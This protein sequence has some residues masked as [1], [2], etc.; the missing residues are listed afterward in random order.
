[1]LIVALTGMAVMAGWLLALGVQPIAI[2]IIISL[3]VISHGV[4][5]RFVAETGF[6]FFRPYIS[7]VQIFS[8]FSPAAFSTR[9]IYFFGATHLIGPFTARESTMVFTTHG[10][11]AVESPGL[12][13]RQGHWILGLIVWSIALSLVVAAISSLHCYY[14]YAVPLTN[15]SNDTVI[16]SHGLEFMPRTEI[17]DRMNQHA[18][19][20]WPTKA[21]NPWQHIGIGALVTAVLQLG[22]WRYAWWPLIPVGYVASQSSYIPQAWF[23]IF[24]GWLAKI[25]IVRFG[26]TKLYHHL[27]PLFIGLVFG[28]GLVTG[29]WMVINLILA[30]NGYDYKMIFF[31]PG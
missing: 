11:R 25:T 26:G 18:S 31:L 13:R 6:P 4:V 29:V 27:R 3:I 30:M 12:S 20:H 14:T 1:L 2:A 23:S 28:E 7:A 5:A 24:I 8:N 17:V 22:A 19:G 9:D 21:F 16:N 15:Q 10:L